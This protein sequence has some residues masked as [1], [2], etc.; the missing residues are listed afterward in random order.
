MLKRLF[1]QYPKEKNDKIS[2]I[3]KN[4]NIEIFRGPENNLVKR[5][6]LAAKKY[7]L[8]IYF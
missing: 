4:E 7:N 1:L 8:K 3:F 6:Y 2:E 5:Y